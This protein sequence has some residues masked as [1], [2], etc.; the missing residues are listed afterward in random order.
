MNGA[1]G[2]AGLKL[3]NTLRAE[4]GS[5]VGIRQDRGAGLLGDLDRVADV[6]AVAVRE[7]DMRQAG[8]RVPA[9]R[10]VKGRVAG[11]KR[12]DQDFRLP[13]SMRKAEWPSQ[14]I[15]MVFSRWTSAALCHRAWRT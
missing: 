7:Q 9:G 5:K 6:V 13:V 1:A 12:I 2:V 11:E 4:P 10:F 8:G 3:P 15:F 14:V